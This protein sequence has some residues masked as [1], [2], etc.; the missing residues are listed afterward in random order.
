MINKIV[1]APL[2]VI[3]SIGSGHILLMNMCNNLP[4]EGW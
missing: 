1:D 4:S 3:T 2:F